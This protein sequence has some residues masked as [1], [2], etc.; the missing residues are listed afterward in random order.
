MEGLKWEFAL[1]KANFQL[2]EAYVKTTNHEA[3][4]FVG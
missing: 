4:R 3:A 1:A 2:L